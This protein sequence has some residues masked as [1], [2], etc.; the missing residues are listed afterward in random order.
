MSFA[1]SSEQIELRDSLRRF[2]GATISTEY[3]RS[4]FETTQASDP[5][6]WAKL[7]EFGFLELFSDRKSSSVR[8]LVMTAQ[9]AGRVLLPENIIDTI[10]VL[11]SASQEVMPQIASGK[12][13]VA[14][15]LDCGGV[16]RFCSAGVIATD[17]VAISNDGAA[18]FSDLNS[19]H[20]VRI[21]AVDR[22]LAYFDL[23]LSAAKSR[24]LA[25]QTRHE[26]MLARAAELVGIGEIVLERTLEYAKTRK[27]FGVTIGSFQAVAHRLAEMLLR[28]ESARSLVE[29]AAWTLDSSPQQAQLATI[30]ACAHSFDHIPKLVEESIQIHGGIGFTWEYDLHFFLR[31]AKFLEAVWSPRE[32]DLL[33]IL[34][35]AEAS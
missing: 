3:L 20:A 1:L 21:D 32:E 27:Q 4:R 2:L 25:A 33:S 6:V 34:E 35:I 16:V 31:R 13:R 5:A 12:R 7:C 26:L 10:V 29:F 22:T 30:S 11:R 18:Y 17:I 23:D 9:E 8:D 14:I 28:L 15:G 19:N 24:K